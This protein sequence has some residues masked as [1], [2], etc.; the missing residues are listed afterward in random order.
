MAGQVALGFVGMPTAMAQ[1]KAGRLRFIAVTDGRRAAAEPNLP[2]VAEGGLKGY[3]AENWIGTLAPAA[4]PPRIIEQMHG[5]VMKILHKPDVRERL[6]SLG[7][8][9]LGLPPAEFRTL[10]E[11]DIKSFARV[12]EEAKIR[13]N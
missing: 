11:R 3:Q 6:E 1:A 4:T 13:V 10:L 9:V 7:F 5:E 2:T 8:N 12:I